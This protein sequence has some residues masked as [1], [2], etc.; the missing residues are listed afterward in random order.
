M[1]ERQRALGLVYRVSGG[2]LLSG[3]VG[4][5]PLIAQASGVGGTVVDISGAPVPGADT[6]AVQAGLSAGNY[7]FVLGAQANGFSVA[8][9]APGAVLSPIALTCAPRPAAAHRRSTPLS[10]G[11][12]DP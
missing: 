6:Y 3:L 8:A 2:L 5:A 4:V 1:T 12:A 7:V 10:N 11:P 9:P